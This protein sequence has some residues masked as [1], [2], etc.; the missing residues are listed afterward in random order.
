MGN[1]P[2]IRWKMNSSLIW[3]ILQADDNTTDQG[4]VNDSRG[5]ERAQPS[6]GKNMFI[7]LETTTTGAQNHDK[8]G[9]NNGHYGPK[10]L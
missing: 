5:R 10:L 7:S 8:D 1:S 4:L 6:G 2:S 3:H 9:N